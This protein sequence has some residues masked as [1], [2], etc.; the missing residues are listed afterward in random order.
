MTNAYILDVF[1]TLVDCPGLADLVAS[2]PKLRELNKAAM[3]DPD[4][5]TQLL[6]IL[7]QKL[8]SGEIASVEIPGTQEVLEQLASQ[9]TLVAYSS[10]T[11]ASINGL[12]E[13]SGLM[14]YFQDEKLRISDTDTLGVRKSEPESYTKLKAYL[15]EQGLAIG[16]FVD[17]TEKNVVAAV[18]SEVEIP[19]IYHFDSG[20]SGLLVPEQMEGYQKIGSLSQMKE[21]GE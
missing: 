5:R 8:S 11:M 12:L 6:H 20:A 7:V 2:D 17:N 18:Q 13:H 10:G 15:N 14:G 9:G 3:S 4:S 21:L 19:S 16:L 1:E